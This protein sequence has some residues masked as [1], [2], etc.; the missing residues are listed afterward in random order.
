MLPAAAA[1]VVVV[2]VVAGE[3]AHPVVGGAVG[4]VGRQRPRS[5]VTVHEVLGVDALPATVAVGGVVHARL[6]LPPAAGGLVVVVVVVVGLLGSQRGQELLLRLAAAL[7]SLRRR[8]VLVGRWGLLL[9]MEAFFQ[10]VL[11]LS[12]L[13]G[14][15]LPQGG[16][17]HVA[18][19]PGSGLTHRSTWVKNQVKEEQSEGSIGFLV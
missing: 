13:L 6:L 15:V 1:V 10:L 17:G 14:V 16:L 9:V 3:V 8:L 4:E 2:E 5:Q 11:Q 18:P 19:F 7:G 12:H